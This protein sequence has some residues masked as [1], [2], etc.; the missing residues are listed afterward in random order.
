MITP[1]T[2]APMGLIVF[3]NAFREANNVIA[4]EIGDVWF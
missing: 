3:L 1:G 4:V 2:T